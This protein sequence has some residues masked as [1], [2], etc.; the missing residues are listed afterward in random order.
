MLPVQNKAYSIF[1]YVI[2]LGSAL[3][4][5]IFLWLSATD[6]L[7]PNELLGTSALTSF[8]AG[9][10]VFYML[11]IHPFLKKRSVVGASLIGALLFT[12]NLLVLLLATGGF[13]SAYFALWLLLVLAVGIYRP[14]VPIALIVATTVYF[15]SVAFSN[16]FSADF[17][18]SNLVALFATYITGLLGFWLWHSHHT[19]IRDNDSLNE[20]SK[21]LT[22]EQLKSEI[23]I[24]GM[25]DAVIV[26]DVQSRIQ[27]L[28]HAAEEL[29]GWLETEAKGID[30]RLVMPLS[31]ERADALVADQDPVAK[32]IATKQAVKLDDLTLTDRQHK[33]KLLEFSA[34]PIYG[35]QQV[36]SGVIIV[37][38]D[39][40]QV[41]TNARERDEFISTASH[42][43]RTPVAAIEG[44]V[45]LALNPKVSKIDDKARMYLKKAQDTTQ[46][47]GRLFHDLLSVTKL[48]EG[49]I[50][51][52]KEV[53]EMGEL[54]KSVI[55]ELRFKAEQNHLLLRI[56][57]SATA[58]DN[59]TIQPLYR[60]YAD[61]ERLREVLVNLID[62][63]IKF[64]PKG[65][66]SVSLNSQSNRLVLGV[67]DTG[68]GID[69]NEQKH[70]FQKFYRIDNSK[71]RNI[72]GTGLGLYLC[73]TIV[74]L[75][76][77]RIWVESKSGEGSHFYI[78]LPLL[79]ANDAARLSPTPVAPTIPAQVESK[80]ITK[81]I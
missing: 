16:Q 52:H 62:N 36:V 14:G 2:T 65:E 10:H 51:E 71:T 43:M 79:S 5:A 23:L 46:H 63:A 22:E 32:A 80:V 53:V 70:L 67:H 18:T 33:R 24:K 66:V 3:V 73:R 39:V 19:K 9:S 41:K 38:R 11:A 25:A 68:I 56:A 4:V 34:S 81:R 26:V 58:S 42:E 7:G 13:G 69:P 31:D 37:A 1:N 21:Q 30:W 77:G 12:T 64:T 74:E 60:V 28:N 47:L 76:N 6:F 61:P 40:T 27:L 54:V 17:F 45:A 78:S 59:K 8:I 35:S 29:T 44:F 57:S 48:E 49:K 20:L 50:A 75:Y 72:G 55:D 15:I